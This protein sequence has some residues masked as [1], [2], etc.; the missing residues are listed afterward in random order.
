MTKLEKV[1]KIRP[2][3][4]ENDA[5]QQGDDAGEAEVEFVVDICSLERVE[6]GAE[7]PRYVQYVEEGHFFCSCSFDVGGGR[8]FV[9]KGFVV[10]GCY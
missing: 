10:S 4:E 8:F 6:L 3:K 1:S 2:V 9:F 5:G 7:Q